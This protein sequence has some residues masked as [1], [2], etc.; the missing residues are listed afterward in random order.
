MGRGPTFAGCALL[1]VNGF[2]NPTESGDAKKA[3][4]VFAASEPGQGRAQ[5]GEANP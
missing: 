5:P 3:D 1:H 2:A 4:L